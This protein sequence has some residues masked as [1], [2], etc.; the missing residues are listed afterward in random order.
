[1]EKRNKWGE[2]Y[3]EKWA[4]HE[5]QQGAERCRDGDGYWK[6]KMGQINDERNADKNEF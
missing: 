4:D 3:L 2:N 5:R 1:M 6:G